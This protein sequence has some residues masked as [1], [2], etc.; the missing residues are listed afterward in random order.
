VP[1][2]IPEPRPKDGFTAQDCDAVK[3]YIR[4]L[5]GY[6]AVFG[7]GSGRATREKPLIDRADLILTSCGPRERPL[8]YRGEEELRSTGLSVREARRLAIGDISGV[9]LKNPAVV[10]GGRI[11]AINAQLVSPGLLDKFSACSARAVE[12]GSGGTLV[13]AIGANK[14]ETLVEIVRRGLA[15]AIAIDLDL[16][17]AMSR[18]LALRS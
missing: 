17:G 14:A 11:D 8:G 18:I 1:S 5:P 15:T 16:A 3:R 10:D 6:R 13:C 9:L 12:R 7:G 2:R 4:L